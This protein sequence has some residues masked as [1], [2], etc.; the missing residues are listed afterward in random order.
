MCGCL[1]QAIAAIVTCF[2]FVNEKA[3]GKGIVKKARY[4][5]GGGQNFQGVVLQ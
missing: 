1:K 2:A 3:K 4:P 5:C